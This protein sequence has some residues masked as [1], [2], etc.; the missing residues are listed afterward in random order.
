MDPITAHNELLKKRVEAQKEVLAGIYSQAMAYTN[1]VIG[2]G[3][4]A[5]FATWAFTRSFLT[6]R[7]I[8]WSALLMTI[9][10]LAFVAFEVYKSFFISL[11]VLKLDKATH[12]V[13]DA[14]F[15]KAI[16]E[17]ERDQ[18][19]RQIVAGRV[20]IVAFAVCVVTG[21]GAGLVLLYAF[22]E[23]LLWDYRG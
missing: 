6:P 15:V 10:V 5:F 3:Y 1:L 2:A 13:N 12:A 4:V 7:Q 9:S 11:S 19:T 14:S 18:R 21:F 16:Q 22:V 20:W 23:N 17:Y 8:L